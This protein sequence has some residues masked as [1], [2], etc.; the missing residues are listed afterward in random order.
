MITRTEA[1]RILGKEGYAFA[2]T[3]GA[4]WN[5]TQAILCGVYHE[6]DRQGA[7]EFVEWA[8]NRLAQ[9]LPIDDASVPK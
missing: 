2:L 7:H 9:G 3:K 5:R 6:P 1:V 8:I 4:A